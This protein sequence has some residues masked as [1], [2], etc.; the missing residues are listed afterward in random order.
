ML[1]ITS[2]D[3]DESHIF[4]NSSRSPTCCTQVSGNLFSEPKLAGHPE[5]N[6]IYDIVRTDY[7][8]TR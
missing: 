1:F 8:G 6:R 5:V 2:T 3:T 7:T 4:E